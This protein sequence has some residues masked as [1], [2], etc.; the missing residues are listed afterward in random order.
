[1]VARP[2][3]KCHRSRSH[4]TRARNDRYLADEF[5]ILLSNVSNAIFAGKALE[6][7]LPMIKDPESLAWS[8][9]FYGVD[10]G[11]DLRRATYD[12]WRVCFPRSIAGEDG[13]LPRTPTVY[14]TDDPHWFKLENLGARLLEY[15]HQI[16]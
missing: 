10:G 9:G 12:D 16:S 4:L 2:R 6:R 14:M 8:E 13:T 5:G 1:M 7:G 15:I 3:F 11:D